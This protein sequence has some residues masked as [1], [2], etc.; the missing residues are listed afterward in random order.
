MPK[1]GAAEGVLRLIDGERKND[2]EAETEAKRNR[3]NFTVWNNGG[4]R[5]V[6]DNTED[7]RLR[8]VG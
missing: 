1:R 6:A 3:Q 7:D 2:A 5:I 4:L 8:K